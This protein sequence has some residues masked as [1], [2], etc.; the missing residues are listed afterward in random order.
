MPNWHAE[1][2]FLCQNDLKMVLAFYLIIIN[3][4]MHS[5]KYNKKEIKKDK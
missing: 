2:V 4:R 3:Q 1:Y 5:N